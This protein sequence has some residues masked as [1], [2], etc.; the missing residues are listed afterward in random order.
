M[1]VLLRAH[2]GNGGLMKIC[3]AL[4]I[5]QYPYFYSHLKLRTGI[6]QGTGFS[7]KFPSFFFFFL[8][9][10]VKLKY[11]GQNPSLAETHFF[12]H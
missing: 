3:V 12:V 11:S 1:P 4:T 9:F 2:I 8:F 5:T 10:D 7:T 6:A